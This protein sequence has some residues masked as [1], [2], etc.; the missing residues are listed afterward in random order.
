[1]I[2]HCQKTEAIMTYQYEINNLFVNALESGVRH[3]KFADR[4]SIVPRCFGSLTWHSAAGP[5]LNICV[6]AW[7]Y[8]SGGNDLN[9]CPDTNVCKIVESV[10]DFST[11][12]FGDKRT[13]GSCEHNVDVSNRTI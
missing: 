13:W 2:N 1:M 9:G 8:I 5:L 10:I 4:C 6:D 3:W 11:K 12:D 7:S